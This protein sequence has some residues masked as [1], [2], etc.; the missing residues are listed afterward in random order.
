MPLIRRL[1]STSV[2]VEV[3]GRDAAKAAKRAVSDTI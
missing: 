2:G 3:H 1:T